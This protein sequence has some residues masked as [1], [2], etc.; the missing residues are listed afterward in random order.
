MLSFLLFIGNAIADDAI[1]GLQS[2]QDFAAMKAQVSK[3]LGDGG[4]YKE[5]SPDD[6]KTVVTTLDRMDV[7]WQNADAT[8]QL[9]PEQRADMANDQ[10]T[11]TGILT[12]ASA[13]SRVVCER[14][15]PTNSH[16]PKTVCRTV[17]QMRREQKEAAGIIQQGQNH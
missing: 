3:D 10:E 8:G 14:F 16:L 1:H 15:M 12:H 13:E 17:A 2:K 4:K 11:V 5:I 6:Q 9:N 7:R